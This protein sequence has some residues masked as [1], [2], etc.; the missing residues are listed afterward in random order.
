VS[1]EII[2][3][4][5]SRSEAPN[6]RERYVFVLTDS[7]SHQFGIQHETWL[8]ENIGD[9]WYYTARNNLGIELNSTQWDNYV[10]V[11]LDRANALLFMMSAHVSGYFSE[12]TVI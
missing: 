11:V 10:L 6:G 1:S 3:K 2:I 9:N 8:D 5:H 7:N 12:D 4:Y